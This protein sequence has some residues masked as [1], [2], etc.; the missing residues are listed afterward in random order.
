MATPTTTGGAPDHCFGQPRAGPGAAGPHAA[1]PH[2]AGPHAAQA[3][4]GDAGA[5]LRLAEGMEEKYLHYGSELS[6]R[7]RALVGLEL[8]VEP[9]GD[10]AVS[11]RATERVEQALAPIKENLFDILDAI[12]KGF[13]VNEIDGET[14]AKQWM[15]AGL[16]YLQPYWL[17]IRREEPETL[18][19][20]TD[21]NT[22]G[23]A[24][25]PYKFITHK[26]KAKSGVLIR[27]GLARMACGAFLFSNYAIKDW[28]TFAEAY[29]RPLRV[30]TLADPAE[31]KLLNTL[32]DH[33]HPE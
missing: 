17:Q 23:D 14:S 29:G 18:Y 13:S 11:Q 4:N 30:G 15:P 3:V 32:A 2:A 20:R 22:Y 16:S 31:Q 6:T 26:I 10:D 8:Y 21:T 27:G 25:A 19:L 24:L 12:G 7:K 9:A 28:A 1:G 5:Y 33:F